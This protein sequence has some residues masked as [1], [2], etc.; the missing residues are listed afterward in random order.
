MMKENSKNLQGEI[1]NLPLKEGRNETLAPTVEFIPN[2]VI[3]EAL[4][5]DNELTKRIMSEI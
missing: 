2:D 1:R 4:K 5:L 3:T